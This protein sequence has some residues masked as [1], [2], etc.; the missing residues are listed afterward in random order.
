MSE[1]NNNEAESLFATRRKKQQD[2]EAQRAALK[3]EEERLA[4]LERQKQQMAE[5][6]KKLEELQQLQ[7]QQAEMEA[8]R[9]QAEREA[10]AAQKAQA[11]AEARRVREEREALAAQKA[12]A[13]IEALRAREEQQALARQQAQAEKEA[14]K[15]L[16]AQQ[17]ATEQKAA[18][19][20]AAEQRAL[21]EQQA[22][23]AEEAGEAM[24]AVKPQKPA[25]QG[26][27][28]IKK[29]LPFI[30]GGVGVVVVVVVVLLVTGVFSSKDK[31][32]G[33]NYD[34]EDLAGFVSSGSFG[35]DIVD[36]DWYRESGRF[37]TSFVYPTFFDE[38]TDDAGDTFYYFFDEAS[39]QSVE[40]RVYSGVLDEDNKYQLLDEDYIMNGIESGMTD[41]GATS[42]VFNE[43]GNNIW[44]ANNSLDDQGVDGE[45]AAVFF[46]IKDKSYYIEVDFKVTH[47]YSD[48]VR[49]I[50]IED[51]VDMFE[52]M[53]DRLS[54][55]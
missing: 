37:E 1:N 38:Y 33:S 20:R 21:R 49:Y 3:A 35:T 31:K 13:Q 8:Q 14:Q 4:E 18:E 19:Q 26:S 23:A 9:A 41:M 52:I 22:K 34:N 51:L 15:A 45:M 36:I 16:K 2:E 40:M 50:D 32:G 27:F 55:G 30:L 7:K 24:E 29:Y 54:V 46:G 12:Q 44:Y 53:V 48:S 42:Y 28:D 5:E 47:E 39:G 43:Q 10:L 11:E 17:K 6:L 25:A